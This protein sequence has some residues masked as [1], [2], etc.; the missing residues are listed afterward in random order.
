MSKLPK[1]VKKEDDIIDLATGYD[2]IVTQKRMG[3]IFVPK[4]V[5]FQKPELLQL[6]MKNVIVMNVMTKGKYGDELYYSCI[7]EKF[8]ELKSVTEGIPAYT[9]TVKPNSDTVDFEL[10]TLA[11]PRF[12]VD[13][14]DKDEADRF[15]EGVDTGAQPDT[16]HDTELSDIQPQA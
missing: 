10:A 4:T 15:K 3:T 16:Q 8:D 7:S 11:P 12:R 6:I 9:V 14:E 5:L 13:F 1:S 2:N